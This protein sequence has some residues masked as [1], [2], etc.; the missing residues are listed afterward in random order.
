MN[1]RQVVYNGTEYH[2]RKLCCYVNG[3]SYVTV[4]K[5]LANGMSFTEAVDAC[6]G[7]HTY[8]CND[9]PYSDIMQACLEAEVEIVPVLRRV[10]SGVTLSQAVSESVEI[11]QVCRET[12]LEP[13][14][15]FRK[16]ASGMTVSE[17]VGALLEDRNRKLK[18]RRI[19]PVVVDK[20]QYAS[21]SAAMAA[22]GVSKCAVVGRM[23]KGATFEDALKMEHQCPVRVFEYNNQ[24]F[25]GAKSLAD[26]LGVSVRFVTLRLDA[27]K[28]VDE[29]ALEARKYIEQSQYREANYPSIDDYPG[30]TRSQML[31]LIRLVNGDL[32]RSREVLESVFLDSE[33][34]FHD[35]MFDSVSEACHSLGDLC[36]S[37]IRAKMMRHLMTFQDAV[38][39]RYFVYNGVVYKSS[40]DFRIGIGI[41]TDELKECFS[42]SKSNDEVVENVI[43]IAKETHDDST[44][45]FRKKVRALRTSETDVVVNLKDGRFLVY[46]SVCGQ[47]IIVTEKELKEFKHS[48][49]F[50]NAHRCNV[51]CD[52]DISVST[53]RSA[54]FRYGSLEAA[55]KWFDTDNSVKV[56]RFV[57]ARKDIKTARLLMDDKYIMCVCGVCGKSVLLVPKEARVF[58]H[59]DIC[60]RYEWLEV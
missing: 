40:S 55:L 60:E 57:L 32:L 46:C 13:N 35:R 2:D 20:V 54:F 48:Y 29:I 28:S 25:Y 49:S 6:K 9:V 26:E 51:L 58:K 24:E 33:T 47:A 11:A 15:V 45:A 8:L 52:N 44:R 39:S 14:K 53:F 36:I 42:L 38:H 17:A 3:A 5:Y 16:V 7:T 43:R 10:E 56:L 19:T 12:G 31:D 4:N 1:C 34:K 50:C 18:N 27:G 37:D 59:S 41:T 30:C 21:K 23:S 22:Y